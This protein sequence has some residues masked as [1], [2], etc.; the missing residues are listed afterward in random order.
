MNKIILSVFL[1]VSCTAHAQTAEA[2]RFAYGAMVGMESQSIGGSYIKRADAL[3]YA[4]AGHPSLGM[5]FGG[6]AQWSLTKS[7]AVRP[8]LVFAYNYNDIRLIQN[9]QQ[10][11][12]VRYRFSDVELPLHFVA[13]NQVGDL[14]IRASVL[15]GGRLSWNF[16]S[17]PVNEVIGLYHERLGIDIGLGAECQIGAWKIKPE[18]IYS[19]GVNNIHNVVNLPYDWSIG[20]VVRDRLSIRVLVWK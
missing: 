6:F 18:V 5:S 10:V 7:I 13:T 1:L 9:I 8:Q 11:G 2:C 20:R 14:P 15:L 4:V 12:L 19:Y 3:P 17:D 16:A